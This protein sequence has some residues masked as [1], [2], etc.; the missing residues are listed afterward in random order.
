[1]LYVSTLSLNKIARSPFEALS[2]LFLALPYTQSASTKRNLQ[3]LISI[4]INLLNY[5]LI[6][7]L[8][9]ILTPDLFAYQ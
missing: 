7:L 1:M 3:V 2:L 4:L 5:R 8:Q 9:F 6:Y